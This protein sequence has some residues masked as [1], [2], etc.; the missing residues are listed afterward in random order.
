[1]SDNARR[2]MRR[3][4][5]P[6]LCPK[7]TSTETRARGP[8]REF[9]QRPPCSRD[10][11]RKLALS[12][13][14]DG[15]ANY[16]ASDS[17]REPLPGAQGALER[18]RQPAWGPE[19]PRTFPAAHIRTTAG[20]A[21]RPWSGPGRHSPRSRWHLTPLTLSGRVQRGLDAIES[22]RDS[23]SYHTEETA[24]LSPERIRACRIETGL[25]VT[26]LKPALKISCG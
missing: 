12:T 15:H 20:T 14:A 24:E 17:A 13:Q 25:V 19:P 5:A 23:F 21:D 4:T 3:C 10:M 18:F 9:R 22:F 2:R 1:M 26:N 11:A 7:V 8:G 6:P 16:W